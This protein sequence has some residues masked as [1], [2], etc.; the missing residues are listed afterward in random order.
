[1]ICYD[2]LCYVIVM[3]CFSYTCISCFHCIIIIIKINFSFVT[4]DQTTD[5][6]EQ[7]KGGP[8]LDH[9]FANSW[10]KS[11][12]SVSASVKNC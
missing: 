1:M 9:N 11:V 3:L 8:A 4:T 12:S 10:E 6:H 2:M 5:S 7:P